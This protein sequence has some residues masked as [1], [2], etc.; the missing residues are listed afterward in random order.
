M[1]RAWG[2]RCSN[3]ARSDEHTP[4]NP[5]PKRQ[6]ASTS[7][8]ATG[9]RL[10]PL[11][12]PAHTKSGRG[13]VGSPC[14]SQGPHPRPRAKRLH[15]SSAHPKEVQTRAAK[16]QRGAWQRSGRHTP[17]NERG[18]RTSRASTVAQ[19]LMLTLVDS[20]NR[21]GSSS[22]AEAVVK[23][24]APSSPRALPPASG[25]KRSS[26]T[27]VGVA[28]CMPIPGKNKKKSPDVSSE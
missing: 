9:L 12:R 22:R 26:S 3:M 24:V 21:G 20:G 19:Q 15:S 23:P 18:S 6:H 28:S 25:V 1:H 5:P 14:T 11:L 7:I 4:G 16:S 17:G 27:G 8:Q 2:A 13:G 10:Q